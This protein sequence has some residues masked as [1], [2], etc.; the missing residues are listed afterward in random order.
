MALVK[1]GLKLGKK[2]EVSP[3]TP[4]QTE[5]EEDKMAPPTSLLHL[6]NTQYYEA[7]MMG[8][9]QELKES[10]NDPGRKERV[11]GLMNAVAVKIEQ[12]Q[13]YNVDDKTI[14]DYVELFNTWLLGK[15]YLNDPK[16]GTFWG[17]RP[18][19]GESIIAYLRQY[20]DVKMEYEKQ[21]T[22]LKLNPPTDIKSAW[23]FF[24]YILTPER[25]ATLD[26][27]KDFNWWVVPGWSEGTVEGQGGKKPPHAKAT[28]TDV[29][30][31]GDPGEELGSK[32]GSLFAASQPIP[33]S[34]KQEEKQISAISSQQKDENPAEEIE[35]DEEL[36]QDNAEELKR[37]RD[38]NKKMLEKIQGLKGKNEILKALNKE[39]N[40]SYDQLQSESS[41]KDQLHQEQIK[42]K[43][44]QTDQMLTEASKERA[45]I[46]SNLD[47]AKNEIKN[48]QQKLESVTAEKADVNAQLSTMQ[49]NW[50]KSEEAKNIIENELEQVKKKNH[51]M[52][53]EGNAYVNKMKLLKSELDSLNTLYT[54]EKQ[55]NEAWKQTM[56]ATT[57]NN[58]ILM[59]EKS[60]NIEKMERELT[61]LRE[62]QKSMEAGG[63]FSKK[64]EKIKELE[65][66]VSD[67]K[68]KYEAEI[69]ELQDE[70]D[71]VTEKLNQSTTGK[72]AKDKEI[73]VLSSKRKEYEKKLEIQEG[74]LKGMKAES[75][76]RFK[77]LQDKKKKI[78]ELES[79]V[80]GLLTSEKGNAQALSTLKKD[81]EQ[82][83]L[84]RE[85][86]IRDSQE[87]TKRVRDLQGDM[88]KMKTNLDLATQARDSL[89]KQTS[90]L[91]QENMSRDRQLDA[92][93]T[94]WG[95]LPDMQ[96]Y[97]NTTTEVRTQRDQAFQKWFLEQLDGPQGGQFVDN[98]LKDGNQATKKFVDQMMSNGAFENFF[99]SVE[100]NNVFKDHY[101]RLAKKE[102]WK[103]IEASLK[104]YEHTSKIGRLFS[105]ADKT[106]ISKMMDTYSN[107]GGVNPKVLG[108]ASA[109]MWQSLINNEGDF[110][111][112]GGVKTSEN[113]HPLELIS[114][115]FTEK[116]HAR[117]D[118]Y[119]NID[120]GSSM[121]FSSTERKEVVLPKRKEKPKKSVSI[122]SPPVPGEAYAAEPAP[123]SSSGNI[124]SDMRN[125]E[126]YNMEVDDDS[127]PAKMLKPAS[128]KGGKRI[129]A[130][131]LKEHYESRMGILNEYDDL[132]GNKFREVL[133]AWEKNPK[134]KVVGPDMAK[135]LQN[136]VGSYFNDMKTVLTLEANTLNTASDLFREGITLPEIAEIMTKTRFSVT[137][138]KNN[139]RI[140]TT[141]I[142]W[143]QM[144]AADSSAKM[145]QEKNHFEN[146]LKRLETIKNN[147]EKFDEISREV[148]L[149]GFKRNLPAFEEEVP[150]GGGVEVPES[151]DEGTELSESEYEEES[152]PKF[153]RAETKIFDPDSEPEE[154][155]QERKLSKKS[156][157]RVSARKETEILS[158]SIRKAPSR[159]KTKILKN[160]PTK[161]LSE[162]D[163]SIKFLNK[164]VGSDPSVIKQIK[165]LKTE[166]KVLQRQQTELI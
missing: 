34:N 60:Q 100:E 159:Q 116:G 117:I 138:G 64:D 11:I 106:R 30:S 83:K 25:W 78:K 108:E 133:A 41:K 52:V 54:S 162:I 37:L 50:Q 24:K 44:L 71:E 69:K 93:R 2:F 82:A 20:V 56:K 101:H 15:S 120:E 141:P 87:L 112:K 42:R 21:L 144:F 6:R 115:F 99:K 38:E 143:R 32:T 131:T 46:S 111:K 160:A 163:S 103:R 151:E 39:K 86:A 94:V 114:K 152:K 10:Y 135:S 72:I 14:Q 109:R 95:N 73:A 45:T 16:Y 125:L 88:T 65:E 127:L 26:F 22:K 43:D 102:E 104:D 77:D 1:S 57:D 166:R 161:R 158:D 70:N 147:P 154:E 146:L 90:D 68:K 105:Q 136:I 121:K 92:Y 18:L 149:A 48:Y 129:T 29:L 49:G 79:Q 75:E 58:E 63:D 123:S 165:K 27:H 31:M 84:E 124:E 142:F 157:T 150:K 126:N 4:L 128:H 81:Y 35:S 132:I 155:V 113:I 28:R 53:A 153:S 51:E 17:T 76:A 12:Q 55:S 107:E 80:G 62:K 3:R 36:E 85:A 59:R 98:L 33:S 139:E 47:K 140:L 19:I 156:S 13:N 40:N 9:M 66:R 110:I 5:E 91:A 97:T 145:E 148:A 164:Q 61:E 89:F 122:S 7:Q 74:Q 130:D 118:Q 23:L 137:L 96:D 119:G 134:L 67:I 8:L